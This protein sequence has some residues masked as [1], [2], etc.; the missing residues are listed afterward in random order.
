MYSRLAMVD[1][2]LGG[3]APTARG[4]GEVEKL[5]SVGLGTAEVRVTVW[6]LRSEGDQIASQRR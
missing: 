2:V 6:A 4:G 1:E 3:G 5:P